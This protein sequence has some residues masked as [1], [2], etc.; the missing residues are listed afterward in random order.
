M[1]QLKLTRARTSIRLGQELGRGG[2]GAVFAV[3]GQKD[4]VAKLYS[5]LPDQRKIQKLLVM[6][7]AAS[8]SLL[9]IAAWPIDLLSDNNGAVRGFIMPRVIARRDIHEL[10]SPKSRSESFPQADFRFLVHV[11]ANIARAFAVIHKQGHVVGDVNHGNLLVGSDGT[12]ML[13]DCDSFQIGNGAHVFTCDV[14]VPLFTAP[15]LHGGTFRRLVRSANHDRFG[16]AVLIFH[17]LYMGRH[18]FAG[19][20]SGPGEMPI[21]KAVA[22]Y[23]FAYGPDRVANGME[24]PPGTVPLEAMGATIT[25]L[26]IR[27]FGRTG[28]NGMRPDAKTWIEALERLE[29]G[30]RAC[31]Q[32]SSH[33]YPGELVA[34][35]GCT[36]EAQTGIRLFG[37]RI[38]DAGP[39]GAIDLAT[40]WK[41]I[42]AIPDP[43]ADP[44]L[45]S[46]RLWHS[47]PDVRGPSSGL[48]TFRKV[49]S[50]GLVCTGLVACSALSKDG[51]V[52]WALVAYGLAVA[53]WPRV[54]AEKRA[55]AERGY[56]AAKTEWEGALSRWKREA[57]H[58]AFVKKLKAFEQVR[59]E[60]ANLPNKR[61]RQLAKLEAE[62]EMRQRQRYLDRFRI[63]RAKIR[64]IASGRVSMLAS[65]GIET[66]AD[67]DSVNIMR[68]PGFGEMLT[69]ELVRWR[70]RHERNFRFNPGEPIDR[71]DLDAIDREL[72]A[73]RQNLLSTLRQGPDLLRRLSQD[74]NAARTRLMP[75]LEKAW[76]ALKIAE[77][78]RDA[79]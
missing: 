15:E 9:K 13:I 58:D 64:G 4:R 5:S 29:A 41:A 6:A 47:P 49:L 31:S 73:R 14:G 44:A 46:E 21:E 22:E 1:M 16:L 18:P 69:S 17:L 11:G 33:H 8:P 78:R 24:R 51:G 43:G 53:A 77:A 2:E 20:Y 3:E 63:D 23:R 7:E 30:L 37:Q 61:R 74:I 10:Y 34:C 12:V 57:S 66:A 42:S 39:T 25:Q 72:E 56:S 28:S 59:A 36:V 48:K 35:P 52:V 79:L 62:R 19:R 70:Q 71:R 65:Y 40:L 68:I 54:S 50:I 60:I 45:P 26:F 27:A 75:L 32:A 76:I 38:A 67:V 55:A